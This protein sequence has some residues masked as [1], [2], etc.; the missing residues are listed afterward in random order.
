MSE[1]NAR[2]FRKL[3]GTASQKHPGRDPRWWRRIWEGLGTRV[4][5]KMRRQWAG[6][7]NVRLPA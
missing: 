3:A 6:E 7:R 5:G 2:F 1:R 4:R